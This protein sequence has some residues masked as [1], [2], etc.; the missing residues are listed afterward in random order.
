[1]PSSRALMPSFRAPMPSSRAASPLSRPI[2]LLAAGL[3]AAGL[4]LAVLAGEAS[5]AVAPAQ[6]VATLTANH[7]IYAR[8]DGRREAAIS[9]VRPIT[10]EATTLPVLATR[11][12]Y[13]GTWLLVRLPGRLLPGAANGR[14]GW[15]KAV[16][17]R[18]WMIRW[19]I[20]VSLPARV[21][22]IYFAGHLQ[23]SYRVVVGAPASPTP[24]GQFFVEEN[25]AEP[26]SF[27]GAPY[28]LATSARS[29]VFTEFDGGPGQVALHGV[30]GGLGG[31]LGAAQ[32]HG[33]VRFSTAAISWLAA[34]IYPGTPVTITG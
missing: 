5:A 25:I 1:M 13:G 17:T 11:S 6:P 8:P 29:N 2:G 3:L 18:L 24:T 12:G 26:P 23:R 21:A 10:G 31:T 14:T 30:G 32:S 28:A 9:Q 27:P 15:I 4:A 7:A 16:H 22:R 20:V 33:C 19:H 34:Q